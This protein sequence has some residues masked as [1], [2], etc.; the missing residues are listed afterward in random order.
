MRIQLHNLFAGYVLFSFIWSC[1]WFNAPQAA[2][3]LQARL[4]TQRNLSRNLQR[5]FDD[6]SNNDSTPS[7]MKRRRTRGDSLDPDNQPS[8]EEAEVDEI[9]RLGR[10]FVI[11]HGP[12]LRR[13]E[14]IFQVELDEDYDEAERF[15][16]TNTVVQGQLREIRGL[17]PEK[18]LGDAFRKKWLSKSV[19][20]VC[21]LYECIN[22]SISSL[23]EWTPNDPTLLHA[24]GNLRPPYL[25]LTHWI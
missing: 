19:S 18:Y 25:T 9:K 1:K 16:D 17:L 5:K 23:R 2:R 3:E 14:H 7:A 10:R 6:I 21:F 11:L 20:N 22:C 4:N 15:R 12:W 24:S 8:L 13:K